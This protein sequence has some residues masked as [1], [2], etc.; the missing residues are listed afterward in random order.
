[1]KA[2]ALIAVVLAGMLTQG[3]VGVLVGGRETTEIKD[4]FISGVGPWSQSVHEGAHDT[5]YTAEWLRSKWGEPA[6]VRIAPAGA[7]ERW[8]YKSKRQCWFGV[9]PMVII[10]IPL[11]VP[12]GHE[13]IEFVLE[14]GRVVS[15]RRVRWHTGGVMAGLFS[16]EGPFS[17]CGF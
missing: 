1:M 13:K 14:A 9:M 16:A 5:V 4:P 10:P 17:T 11:M 2:L 15:A 6:S 7:V 12:T 3:C 8:T